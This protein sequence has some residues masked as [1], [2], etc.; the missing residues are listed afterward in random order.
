MI[1]LDG[2]QKTPLT[3]TKQ[4]VLEIDEGC[5]EGKVKKG[6]TSLLVDEELK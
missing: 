2:G 6:K 5:L 4:S 1:H 3:G